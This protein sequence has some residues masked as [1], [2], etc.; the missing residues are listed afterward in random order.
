MCVYVHTHSWGVVFVIRCFLTDFLFISSLQVSC[1]HPF[2]LT[3]QSLA[4]TVL[5]Y[6]VSLA[7]TYSP[8]TQNI[9]D[10]VVQ[11]SSS[12]THQ[13]VVLTLSYLILSESMDPVSCP[14]QNQTNATQLNLIQDLYKRWNLVFIVV[15]TV[16]M[17]LVTIVVCIAIRQSSSS[18]PPTGFAAHLPPASPS[19]PTTPAFS[20]SKTTPTRHTQFSTPLWSQSAGSTGGGQSSAFKRTSTG[21]GGGG[22]GTKYPH[23]SPN[24]A[25]PQYSMFSQ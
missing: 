2:V 7:N 6:T 1:P 3:Q 13:R 24:R 14:V 21:G 20:S 18:R 8:P 23:H 25:S 10:V 5:V 9:T 17:F 19:Q 16:V 11:I 12:L 22:G 4:A 15:A